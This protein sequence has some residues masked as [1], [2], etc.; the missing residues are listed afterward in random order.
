MSKAKRFNS[1]KA[2]I[3][4]V[5]ADAV[6]EEAKVW[7]LGREKYGKDEN[8]ST[9]ENWERLWGD[10]TIEVVLNSLLRH[11]YSIKA[12]EVND[13]ESGLQHAA[14]IRCNAAMLIRYF[15]EIK[16]KK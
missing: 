2:P 12:G 15:N 5:P 13:E 11:T 3:Y 7:G 4:L 6:I 14:H 16:V 10:D 1:N 8:D 9:K